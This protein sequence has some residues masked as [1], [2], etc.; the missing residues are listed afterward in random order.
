ML[1]AMPYTIGDRQPAGT[2]L[3]PIAVFSIFAANKSE[4]LATML[5]RVHA[6]FVT[7]GLGEPTV[8]FALSDHL[9]VARR[10]DLSMAPNAPAS[11]PV[12]DRNGGAERG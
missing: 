9:P 4:P 3:M 11:F 6:A 2:T 12:A 1:Q 7:A 8:R 5:A 10:G